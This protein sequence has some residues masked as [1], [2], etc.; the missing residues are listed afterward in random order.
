MSQ[1]IK[2]NL[3]NILSYFLVL[4]TIIKQKRFHNLS[5][6]SFTLRA[7][8]KW[9]NIN[10]YDIINEKAEIQPKENEVLFNEKSY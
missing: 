5:Y 10:E 2:N 3:E 6:N 8:R 1:A 7:S 9:N 4:K